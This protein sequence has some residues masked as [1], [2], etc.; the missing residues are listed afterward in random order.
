MPVVANG[1]LVGRVTAVGPLT[2]QV[3]LITRDKSGLGAVIGEIGTSTA[4]GVISGTSKRDL[5]EMKYVAGSTDVQVGQPVF[6]TGQDGI[7]PPGI[8]VGEIVQV[9]SGSATTPHQ[10][11]IQPAAK[12]GSM[13]E[14]GVLLYEP[15]QKAP[16]DKQLNPPVKEKK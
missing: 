9:I 2:A 3:D 6:T 13:Q 4:L 14:V 7:Y 16:F 10:I 11:F 15:P 8:K 5:L 12:L 1:A